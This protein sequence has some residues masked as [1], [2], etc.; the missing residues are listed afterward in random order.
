[1][2]CRR[3]TDKSGASTL[4]KFGTNCYWTSVDTFKEYA[5]LVDNFKLSGRLSQIS[6]EQAESRQLGW[7]LMEQFGV[8]SFSEV[9]EQNLEPLH[10]WVLGTAVF[11][12]DLDVE[13]AR[14]ELGGSIWLTEEGRKLEKRLKT[15]MNQCYRCHLCERTYGLPDLDSSIQI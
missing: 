6:S 1:L 9:M 12:K 2:T 11:N 14:E 10:L 13:T 4:P 15:C 3:W 8:R 5:G 7:L